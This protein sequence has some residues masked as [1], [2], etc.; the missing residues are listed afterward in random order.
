MTSHFS[1]GRRFLLR[2]SVGAA[3][4]SLPVLHA[5]GQPKSDDS[6]FPKRP[7]RIVVGYPPGQTVDVGARAYA[8][9]LQQLLG[10]PVFVD[11]KAGAN[12]IIGAQTVKSAAA[13]GY[14]LLFGTSGQMTINP[15]IYD[16]LPYDT[17]K[18]FVPVAL[19]ASGRLFLVANAQLPVNTLPELVAYAKAHPKKLSFGSGGA[20]ITAHLAMELLKSETGMDLLHVP[21]KGSP[22]ALTGLLSNDVQLM[23][24]AGSLVLP[25]IQAGKIKVLAVA[26]KDRYPVL[27]KV[28]TVAEQGLPGFEV[29]SWSALFAPAGTPAAVVEKLNA[30][31][32]SASRNDAAMTPIRAGGSEPRALGAAAFSQFVGAEISKWARAAKAANV[33][34]E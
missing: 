17:L 15:A 30:A 2:A 21:Y 1:S 29:A 23:F 24:D 25:Q 13:D 11:N 16:K 26:S 12:G 4:A 3:A 9:A 19:G 10:Q 18:D 22:A 34:V 14:T 32:Q 5:F 8:G 33:K 7:I 20:G 31:M 6:D 27:P 28:P